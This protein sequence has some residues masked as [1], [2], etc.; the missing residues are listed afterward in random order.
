MTNYTTHTADGTDYVVKNRADES[1]PIPENCGKTFTFRTTETA[2]TDY[3]AMLERSGDVTGQFSVTVEFARGGV[4]KTKTHYFA[5]RSAADLF[6]AA[7][8]ANVV[9]APQTRLADISA[10]GTFN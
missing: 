1:M 5:D 4:R 7:W 9:E 6:A 8:G 10:E 2:A 3:A